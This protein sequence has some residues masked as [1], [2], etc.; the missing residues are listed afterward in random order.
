MSHEP[1][2]ALYVRV[3]S[4][5]QDY[6]SQEPDL[7]RWAANHDGPV[8]WYRDTATGRTMARPG[9]ESLWADVQLGKVTRIVVWRLDRLGRTARETIPLFH[10]LRQS[11]VDLISLKDGFNLDTPSGRL[12][13]QLLASFAEYE[14]EVRSERQTAGIAAAK[15]AGRSF[16][17]P[18]GTGRPIKVSDEHRALI[19][20]L[21]AEGRPIAAIARVTRLSRGTIY[22]VLSPRGVGTDGAR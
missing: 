14:T 18:K 16:G 10:E 4:K 12:F 15:A 6:R 8:V 22:A 1:I 7:K 19:V 11:G 5:S 9:W 3:S 21:K 2:T 17:R 13:A 20:R